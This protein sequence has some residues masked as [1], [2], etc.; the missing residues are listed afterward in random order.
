[1][2]Q[3]PKE[4]A[5][6]VIGA[7][8][9]GN[10]MAYHMAKLGWRDIVLLD[11]GPLPN[12]G[13]STGHASNFLFPVDHSK[14]MTKFTQ[15]SIRQYKELGVFTESGGVEVARTPERVEELKRRLASAKAWGEPAE[16]LTPA[17][18]EDLVPFI[19]RDI[20]LGGF[21][22]PGIGV[23][24]SLRAGT[25]MRDEGQRLRALTVLAGTE[26]IGIDASNGRIRGVRT[27]KG[28][29]QTEVIIVAC[30]VW[31][32]RIARMAGAS[33][34]LTPAVHQMIDV[35]PVPILAQTVGEIG[36]PIIRDVDT[37]MYERQHGSEFEIG[38]Y[39]HRP[40][41]VDPDDIPSIDESALSPTELPFTKE[42]FDLQMEQALELFPEILGDE[43]VGIKYAVN[44]LLSLTPD[45]MPILGESPQ[46]RGLWSVAAVWVKEAPAIGRTIA[47]WMTV[48][49]PEIDPHASDIARFYDH[50]RTKTHIHARAAEG[51][52]KTYGIV[53]PFEQWV[54]NREVRLSPFY[55]QEKQLGAT[56]FETAG[57]ERPNWFESNAGLLD[58]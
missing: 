47:E 23:V 40:I 17:E 19:N 15:D 41:L 35:G 44:G 34:P 21:Y 26:V 45:G 28:D 39:A 49:T 3:P 33:I 42:D 5:V 43:Q 10:S 6:V 37:N 8:I 20:V 4:A 36:Y 13:G 50:A 52:N 22:T 53:H 32:P 24:D 38:S 25:L 2:D 54:S 9:Q 18:V 14:E 30:G 31:S 7:G 11:K 1:M 12:P 58:R 46:V 29:I 56:F 48:G 51:Y 55:A 16:L 27:S 57:W